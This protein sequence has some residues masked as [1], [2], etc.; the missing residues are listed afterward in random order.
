MKKSIL[1]ILSLYCFNISFAQ[2]N[3]FPATGNAGIGTTEPSAPLE[4]NSSNTSVNKLLHITSPDADVD[5]DRHRLILAAKPG[6]ANVPYIEWRTNTY[7]RQAYMGWMKDYFN[8]SLENGYHFSINGGYVGIGITNP[9]HRLQVGGTIS[10]RDAW[11]NVYASVQEGN[12]FQLIGTYKGWDAT[13]IY[14]GGYNATNKTGAAGNK[15][16]IGGPNSNLPL[17]VTGNMGLGTTK[18][19][20]ASG[21]EYRLSV[22]GKVRATEVKVYTGWADFVFAPN[23]KLRPLS[24]VESFIKANGHLPEIPAAKEVEANGV[25]I[26]ETQSKLLQKI[27][28]LTLYLIEQNKKLEAQ[29]KKIEALEKKLKQR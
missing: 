9:G 5:V 6:F 7:T 15:V 12:T 19:I 18:T 11:D 23:Y 27:E 28:E 2:T 24:E 16:F 13:A 29:N 14:I 17:F 25:D 4:I 26:G 21:V 20:D 8:L 1:L 22:N 3:T 10:I